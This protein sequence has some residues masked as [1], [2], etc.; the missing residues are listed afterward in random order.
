MKIIRNILNRGKS[1][2]P[3]KNKID[4]IFSD[5]KF[6]AGAKKMTDKLYEYDI[7]RN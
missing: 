3:A 4:R 7:K 5:P 2:T 1:N 6:L